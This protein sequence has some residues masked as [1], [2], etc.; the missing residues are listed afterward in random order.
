MLSEAVFFVVFFTFWGTQGFHCV[1]GEALTDQQ[2]EASA[3]ERI[4]PANAK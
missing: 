3:A 2:R 1:S 4:N